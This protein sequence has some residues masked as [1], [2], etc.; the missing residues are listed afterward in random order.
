[1]LVIQID[2]T[3]CLPN[4]SSIDCT[5]EPTVCS[6]S[7]TNSE[8]STSTN[9]CVCKSGYKLNSSNTGCEKEKNEETPSQQSSCSFLTLSLFTFGLLF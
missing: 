2:G 7:D 4:L 1:M 9:K 6:Q 5:S 8:C 3:K